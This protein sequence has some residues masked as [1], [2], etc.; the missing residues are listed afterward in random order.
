MPD[1]EQ[2]IKALQAR[3]RVLEDENSLLVERA[4][5]LLLLGQISEAIHAEPDIPTMFQLA[6][7]KIA[8]FK[9]VDLVA[10][11]LSVDRGWRIEHCY[12]GRSTED[13]SGLF[14]Q[15][16]AVGNALEGPQLLTGEACQTLLGHISPESD[17]V[18]FLP[19]SAEAYGTGCL[20]LAVSDDKSTVL[21]QSRDLFSRLLDL[22]AMNA[23]NRML[24]H[25]YQIAN[26]ALGQK[27]SVQT[28]EL[29]TSEERF[30]TVIEQAFEAIFLHDNSG[31]FLQVN[32]RACDLLGYTKEEMLQMRVSD[33]DVEFNSEQLAE[34]LQSFKSERYHQVRSIHRHKDGRQLPVEINVSQVRLGTEEYYLA[35]CRDLTHQA[36]AD[37]LRHQLDLLLENMPDMILMADVEGR[38]L[39]MNRAA[40]EI[41]GYAHRGPINLTLAEL[42][43][44]GTAEHCLQQRIPEAIQQGTWVGESQLISAQ[45]ELIPIMQTMVAP[46][47]QLGVVENIFCI[48]RDLRELRKLEAQFIQAQKMEAIGR[49]VGGIAHDFNNV[50]AGITGNVFLLLRRAESEDQQKRLRAVQE[51]CRNA[52]GMVNQLLVFARKDNVNIEPLLLKSF[53]TDFADM[54]QVLVPENVMIR[55]TEVPA[56]LA[57]MTDRTQFQQMLV[58]LL[59]NARDAVAAVRD[60]QI[61]FGV[62]PY[63]ADED[64]LQ[65]HPRVKQN[66]L[67]Q[68]SVADNGCGIPDELLE[69]IFEPFFSTKEVKKGTGLGLAMV[70]GAVARQHGAI[71]I[72][73]QV[74]SGTTFSLFLPRAE[75]LETTL[76]PADD[77]LVFG[78]GEVVILADDDSFVRDS[79]QDAL[80]HLGYRVL[81]AAD[82]QQALETFRSTP[83]VALAICDIVMP[84]LDGITAGEKMRELNSA[85]PLLY[86][87]GYADKVEY[88]DSLPEG[89]EILDK[90]VTVE[91]LSQRVA[92]LLNQKSSLG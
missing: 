37:K 10:I 67:V 46:R 53:L 79:H 57:I 28:T 29:E 17:Q 5:D 11:C 50:L 19:F 76:D 71:E 84:V 51:M 14:I 16:S 58:N 48:D 62:A 88:R 68:V 81:P 92:A 25:N 12:D 66:H 8:L 26:Q 39:Y 89:A 54:Y 33:I 83:E 60:P 78:H 85:L 21:Q 38:L 35:I 20:L 23:S 65:K 18:L 59:T 31:R 4:E 44:A 91:Q 64:F 70:Y 52:A 45:G 41:L 72:S 27:L 34:F 87:S 42:M 24:L 7:E 56:D 49:L 3:L 9:G 15:P 43:P 77:G 75:A 86:M 30:R 32:Q 22:L 2:D 69:N 73:S 13:W 90:P 74:G 55:F 80:E 36:E 61:E 1:Y 82:G 6:L 40:K 47:N 63:I